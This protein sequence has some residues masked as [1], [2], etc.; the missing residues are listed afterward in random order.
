MITL[1]QL[2]LHIKV[3]VIIDAELKPL[4]AKLVEQLSK[5]LRRR[6]IS[7]NRSYYETQSPSSAPS[8]R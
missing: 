3:Y 2:Q 1:E 7:L 8:A 5:P 6:W 4:P